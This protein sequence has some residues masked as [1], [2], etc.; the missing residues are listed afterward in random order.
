MVRKR[1]FDKQVVEI[2]CLEC[3]KK[4][5]KCLGVIRISH[6]VTCSCGAQIKIN[7][8]QYRRI[9]AKVIKD[10]RDKYEIIL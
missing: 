3:G 1:P 7:M 10:L 9:V 6:M 2:P 5:K 8:G 4:I